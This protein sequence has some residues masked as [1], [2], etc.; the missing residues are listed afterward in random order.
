MSTSFHTQGP[1]DRE[2]GWA[3]S[4]PFLVPAV[5]HVLRSIILPF[6]PF[7]KLENAASQRESMGRSVCGHIKS[8]CWGSAAMFSRFRG[9]FKVLRKPRGRARGH[10]HLSN[11]E[12]RAH[13]IS[14]GPWLPGPLQGALQDPE[15]LPSVTTAHC[16][17][18]SDAAALT[19]PQMTATSPQAGASCPCTGSPMGSSA[20]T[21]R[22]SYLC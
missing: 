20:W 10:R 17:T 14:T 5:V 16:C 1:S 9:V 22:R 2:A 11:R 4:F 21:R 7:S 12:S 19:G 8:G 15:V 3:K 13:D 18:C 6:S